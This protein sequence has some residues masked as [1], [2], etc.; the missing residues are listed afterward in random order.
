MTT[1]IG[2]ASLGWQFYLVWAAVAL[3]I[4]PSVYLFYP[5]T[6]GLSVEEIDKVFID[7][8]SVLATVGMAEAR[9]REKRANPGAIAT[10]DVE[11]FDEAAEKHRQERLEQA[12][13]S[14]RA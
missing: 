14:N 13:A 11:Q 2:F 8:P 10:G 4:I 9:R 7:S 12:I 3:S 5:E 6:T 1:P